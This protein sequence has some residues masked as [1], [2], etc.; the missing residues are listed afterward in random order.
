MTLRAILPL[1]LLLAGFA[2]AKTPGELVATHSKAVVATLVE[3]R[4]EFRAD[5][6]KLHAYVRGELTQVF[7]RDYSARL[8]LARHARSAS[9]AQIAAFADALTDNLL[10]RYGS[11][12]LDVDG[13]LEVKILAETPLREGAMMRVNS[14]IVRP[15]GA[16][17][18]IDYLF[19]KTDAGWRAFDVIVEGVSYV[20]T[21]RSQFDSLLR[22]ESLDSVTRRL[23]EGTLRAG[24]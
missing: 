22:T 13:N 17:V 7:D 11:A 16:P 23:A 12:L 20:Q 18:P 9:E 21:Y 1:F 6:A 10:Q 2:Q 5:N 8:V 3:K 14:Q 4:A 15:S 24:E 19:R